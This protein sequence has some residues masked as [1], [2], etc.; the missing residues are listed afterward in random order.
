M[1][2]PGPQGSIPVGSF[3]LEPATLITAR[4]YLVDRV[5]PDCEVIT[6]PGR[7]APGGE[8]PYERVDRIGPPPPRGGW[9]GFLRE[10]ARRKPV[11]L[12]GTLGMDCR[13]SSPKNW[14]HF[15]NLHA[16]LAFELARRLGCSPAD[17]TLILPGNTPAFI[18][19]AARHLGFCTQCADGPV[20]G[21]G[22]AFRLSG[23]IT[24][25]G[26]RKWLDDAGIID[27]LAGADGP[28]LPARI[29]LARR[30]QR[31]ISNQPEIEALLHPLGYVTIYPEDLPV[32][33]QF[34]LFNKAHRIV[35]VHGAGLAPLLFR[36]PGSPLRQMVEILPCG[37]MTDFF[38][39]MAQQV[40]VPW[41][42]VRG[43][44]KPEYV[45]P[46]Y[47]TPGMFKKF[48][49]D[50]FEVDPISLDRA[51]NWH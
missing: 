6:L 39:L 3:P 27:R 28:A 48:S 46:A 2:S 22:V 7:Q 38:R 23:N 14:S 34:R 47:R 26:R 8:I 36:H 50:S 45:V 29:F 31:A 25:P 32:A 37:H 16:P 1:T 4:S 12:R 20:D 44:L 18:L 51:L 9:R 5:V 19:G 15:L 13:V 24:V 42:G 33:Q 21:P 10:G 11:D 17:L 41:I 35:A 43:R 30:K 49:L 40:G